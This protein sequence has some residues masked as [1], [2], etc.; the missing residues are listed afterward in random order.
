MSKVYVMSE[1]GKTE[2]ITIRMTHA[3]KDGAEKLANYLFTVG[4]LKEATI[5]GACRVALRFTI[6]EVLK[7][8]ELERYR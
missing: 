1:A 8:V 4:K 2:Q 6:N 3:E 5:A 7:S